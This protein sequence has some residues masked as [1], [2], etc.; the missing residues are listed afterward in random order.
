MLLRKHTHFVLKQS[1]R[2]LPI[3]NGRNK[4]S[5]KRAREAAFAFKVQSFNAELFIG[6]LCLPTV[7]CGAIWRDAVALNTA[8]LANA[9]PAL[10]RK[11]G[12]SW[13]YIQII[14]F[15]T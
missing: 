1:L 12:Q 9:A 11:G 6:T 15:M 8:A 5:R 14:H 3:K 4:L 13:K 2:V 10:A 7:Q